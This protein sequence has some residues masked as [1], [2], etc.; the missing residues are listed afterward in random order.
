MIIQN[1]LFSDGVLVIYTDYKRSTHAGA[2]GCFQIS[3][4]CIENDDND[5]SILNDIS[6]DQGVHYYKIADVLQDLSLPLDFK[7]YRE[8]IV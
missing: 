8:E 5:I 1:K 6:I 4:I 2:D 7:N 3:N